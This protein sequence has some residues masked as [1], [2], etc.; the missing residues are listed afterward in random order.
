MCGRIATDAHHA[1]IPNL[2]RLDTND[3]RNIIL[4]SHECHISRKFDNKEWRRKFWD[5]QVLR[6]G[7]DVMQEWV[8]SIPA[9][10]RHRLDFLPLDIRDKKQ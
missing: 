4:V 10:F 2:A 3:E 8:D 9:K 1:L 6:Y 7:V 5:R